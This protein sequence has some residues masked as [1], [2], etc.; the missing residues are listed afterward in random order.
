MTTER[1]LPA[2]LPALQAALDGGEHRLYRSGKLP[3]L[4]AA[5]SGAAGDAAA[6]ALREGLLEQTRAETKGKVTAE[7]V[8]LTPAGVR[9]LADH[10]SPRAVLEELQQTLRL[11]QAGV[12]VFLEEFRAGLRALTE[13]VQAEAQRLLG[14]IDELDR[15]LTEALRRQDAGVPRVTDGLAGVV[16]W[17]ADALAHLDG[18]RE[19]GSAECPL[20]ELFAAVQTGRP[21]L[22]VPDFQ[23]GLRRLIDNRAI[24]LVPLP[25]GAD[26]TELDPT[27]AVPD[28]SRL[29][30]HAAR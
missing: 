1:L 19:A 23:D 8:R 29:C 28:G 7:W 26:L 17:A 4:F 15:R 5:R 14:R 2:L 9:F 30:Y 11:T 3:G 21:D 16:P 10:D 13:S 22:T 6:H 12:P 18:R 27:F 24:R 20:A 25:E